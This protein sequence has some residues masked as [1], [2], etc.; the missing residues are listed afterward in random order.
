[1]IIKTKDLTESLERKYR[2]PL[3]E[4]FNKTFPKWLTQALVL[5]RRKTGAVDSIGR[6]TGKDY[7]NSDQSTVTP[8]RGT[9]SNYVGYTLFTQAQRQGFL[10]D[11]V[12][13]IEAPVPKSSRDPHLKDPYTPIYHFKTG[14]VYIPGMNDREN[15]IS[16]Y[17]LSTDVRNDAE[18]MDALNNMFDKPF[19]RIPPKW[20][21]AA[22]D[23]FA[24]FKTDE[25]NPEEFEEKSSDRRNHH[26]EM[27]QFYTDNPELINLSK[28]DISHVPDYSYNNNGRY[29]YGRNSDFSNA[30]D[31]RKAGDGT[32]YSYTSDEY[33]KSGYLI[34]PEKYIDKLKKL[35]AD[36][37]SS[38]LEELHDFIEQA[39]RSY[40]TIYSGLDI[41]DLSNQDKA[42]AMDSLK[43]EL[44]TLSRGY[45]YASDVATSTAERLKDGDI[46]EDAAE[47]KLENIYSDVKGYDYNIKSVTRLIKNISEVT[48]SATGELLDSSDIDWLV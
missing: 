30:R 5:S 9:R 24:Y 19:F 23:K 40:I 4:A 10:S 20:L 16:A 27:R 7:A 21:L 37:L 46:S 15:I 14:Q 29:Q 36:K 44:Q 17:N 33:D 3:T 42:H 18:Y 22:C 45:N 13:V 28:T 26:K 39:W 47:D 43:V 41:F 11:S 1:M 2:Q 12:H 48:D 25:L 31:T 6:I 35:H 34:P 32:Y 38:K 8:E